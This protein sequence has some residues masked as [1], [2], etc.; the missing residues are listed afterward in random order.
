MGI[1]IEEIDTPTAPEEILQELA[2]FYNVIE[3]ENMPGDPPTPLE[4]RIAEWRGSRTNYPV[5]RW[6]LRESG[7]ILGYALTAYDLLQNL[8][9]GFA[10]VHVH[11][12]H[13]GH[14]LARELAA[15]VI[16]DLDSAGRVRVDTWIKR[17]GP[18]EGF[19]EKLGMEA[20]Y[21]EKRSRLLIS[22]LDRDLMRSWIERAAERAD[23]Y[24]LTYLKSPIPD[25]LV[26]NFCDLTDVMNTAPREDFQSED[27]T[28]TPED[29]REM[30]MNVM[31]A[32][33]QLHNLIAIHKPTGDFVGYTQINTKDLEPDLAW[34][35]DTGVHPDHRNKGL[36]RWLKAQMLETIVTD[37]PRVAR[38]DTF[39]AGSNAPMLAINVAMGFKPV[40]LS[41]GWQGDLEKAR[42]GL[43]L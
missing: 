38:I 17:D 21:G 35:W 19:A 13:R 41:Q 25:E 32:H 39:N 9:N 26:Q 5:R 2:V 36:G 40:H 37:Y 8:E 15:S 11:P 10:R 14:G 23:D 3:A 22:E 7:A 29:W 4:M 43:G 27:E 31:A 42:V 33:G 16:D 6:I 18:G 20:V 12:D 30:E 34:Q 28:L 24:E 1:R